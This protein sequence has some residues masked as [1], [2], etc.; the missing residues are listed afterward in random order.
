MTRGTALR[1][2]MNAVE[3]ETVNIEATV[4]VIAETGTE[5]AG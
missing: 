3:V 2:M 5:V 1:D 4:T